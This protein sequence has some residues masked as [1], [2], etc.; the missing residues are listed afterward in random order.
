MATLSHLSPRV[1][2]SWPHA[3]TSVTFSWSLKGSGAVH[4]FRAFEVARV[5]KVVK[6]HEP[7]FVTQFA[8]KIQSGGSATPGRC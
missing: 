7:S 3:R 1:S 5:A 8:W 2:L 6:G 4:R